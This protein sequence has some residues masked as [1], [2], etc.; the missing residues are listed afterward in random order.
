MS[1]P[2]P[3]AAEAYASA[4]QSDLLNDVSRLVAVPTVSADPRCAAEMRRGASLLATQLRAAGLPR[5][6][7]VDTPGHP[8]VIGWWHGAPAAPTVLVYGHYD[9]QPAG[10]G[11]SGSPFTVRRRGDWLLGRGTSDDKGQLLAHVAAIR[12]YLRTAGRLPVNVVCFFDGEEEIG[13]PHLAN[14]LATHRD[15][16]AADAAVVSDTRMLGPHEPVIVTGLRGSVTAELQVRGAPRP[17]HSGSYGGAVPNP[18]NAL[19]RL[20]ASLHDCAGRI[21]V[22]GLAARVR[23][24]SDRRRRELARRTDADLIVRA[25]VP[26]FGEPGYT[27]VERATI[28]PALDVHGLHGGHT[29]PGHRSIVPA[30]ATARI[31]VRLVP[32]QCPDGVVAAL[33][34]HV[35][36]HAPAGMTTRLRIDAR[37]PPVAIDH[38]HPG[39]AAGRRACLR[40]F[41]TE[42]ALLP[43]GGT[44]PAVGLL[45][46]GLDVE[47][48]LLGFALPGD[49][50]HG[51]DERMHIPTLF[52]AV[53]TCVW[54]LHELSRTPALV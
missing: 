45:R 20:V 43:S 51:P 23:T 47:P 16:L 34:D 32:D 31:G 40:V 50:A 44:I 49:R 9:V 12:A 53:K 24:V 41:G 28:R 13:S 3:R 38:G 36:R 30:T 52:R 18:A 11:W 4:H 42:P 6:R 35:R 33:V 17:L 19:C 7:V 54:L 29:G 27:A 25:G 26:G 2:D 21:A 39:I 1:G 10:R 48:L 15:R 22:P 14:V 5:A 46:S 37:T 8:V